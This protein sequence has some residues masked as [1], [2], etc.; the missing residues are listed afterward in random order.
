MPFALALTIVLAAL[1]LFQ[2]ALALGAPIGRFAWGGQHRV[3]PARLRMGSI[4]AIVIYAVIVV[5]A[6]DRVDMIDVVPSTFSTIAMWVI[7]AYFAVGIVMNGVSR[8]R[9]ERY[10]MVPVAAVLA[11][12]SLLIALGY[13]RMAVAA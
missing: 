6:F 8:S 12:L 3:L 7:T 2:L 5:I 11:A 9:P 13:G 1:A 4:V 10:T